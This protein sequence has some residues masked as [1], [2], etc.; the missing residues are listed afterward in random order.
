MDGAHRMDTGPQALAAY[1]REHLPAAGYKLAEYGEQARL[2]RDAGMDTGTLTRLL[3]GKRVPRAYQLWP[4]SQAIR[5]PYAEVLV[6]SGTVP[7][8]SVAQ[9][10]ETAVASQPITADALADQWGV[11]AN[12]DREYIR[13]TLDRVRRLVAQER[14]KPGRGS[15]A[16]H[17]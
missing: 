14:E 6:V 15:S 8:E 16:A 17:G 11:T 9:M 2:A 12:S 10:P 5:R 1:V 3:S 13:D 7:P 4:L